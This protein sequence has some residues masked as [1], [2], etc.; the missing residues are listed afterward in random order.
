MGEKSIDLLTAIIGFFN[1]ALIFLS[2]GFFGEILTAHL[3]KVANLLKSIGEGSQVYKDG[4]KRLET[5]IAEYDQAVFDL[6][7]SVVASN[8][9]PYGLY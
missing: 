3:L 5:A 7:A 8:L 4:K 9:F 6:A 1:S 2:H